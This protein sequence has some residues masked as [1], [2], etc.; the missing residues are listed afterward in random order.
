MLAGS[1]ASRVA[2]CR[3]TR[4]RKPA[5]RARSVQRHSEAPSESYR[6][7]LD[8]VL[9]HRKLANSRAAV[10]FPVSPGVRKASGRL[11]RS[12]SCIAQLFTKATTHVR[13]SWAAASPRSVPKPRSTHTGA[14]LGAL[15]LSALGLGLVQRGLLRWHSRR[16]AHRQLPVPMG[17]SGIDINI[18]TFNIR[19]ISDRWPE[20]G[21]FLKDCLQG[22]DADV[23]CFQEV[24]T[25][26]RLP[27]MTLLEH[28]IACQHPWPSLA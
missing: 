26:R 1:Y 11:S 2:P 16:H 12:V 13:K 15:G 28:S 9:Q 14:G 23:V 4:T 18:V 8:R 5:T 17:S 20:R 10:R 21:P 3:D 27:L 6:E 24:L 25:G 19:G 7:L 22:T